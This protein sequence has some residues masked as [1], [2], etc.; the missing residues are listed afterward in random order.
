MCAHDVRAH[1]AMAGST[2]ALARI[3]R[4]ASDDPC[5]TYL[6]PFG[7]AHY[8]VPA[9]NVM[10]YP[11]YTNQLP[12]HRISEV[13]HSRSPHNWRQHMTYGRV[14]RIRGVEGNCLYTTFVPTDGDPQ[15]QR[16]LRLIPHGA[17]AANRAEVKQWARCARA[18]PD[19]E[20]H[21]S[22][23]AIYDWTVAVDLPHHACLN[24]V[25]NGWP[26]A[27]L[28]YPPPARLPPPVVRSPDVVADPMREYDELLVERAQRLVEPP[29]ARRQK[30]V[31]VSN[32][33]E[34]LNAMHVPVDSAA[35]ASAAEERRASTRAQREADLRVLSDFLFE[36]KDLVL[37][38]AYLDASGALKRVWD[39][40]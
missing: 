21:A 33:Q 20:R 15:E 13:I 39:A 25:A 22:R 26:E 10:V 30:A 1:A 19:N 29:R 35:S 12:S 32:V 6:L 40:L 2:P 38:G 5:A 17:F 9:E 31:D 23:F 3:P 27:E 37:E 7:R 36:C 28:R 4:S 34:F 14:M 11:K 16:V 18:N 24:P 8:Y